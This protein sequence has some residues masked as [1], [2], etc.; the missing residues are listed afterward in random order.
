MS[1]KDCPKH[2]GQRNSA[3]RSELDYLMRELPENQSGTGRHKC[4][5]CAYQKG[6]Q[7]A[8]TDVRA[9]L[10]RLDK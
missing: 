4:P 1:A 6:Y 3:G 10:M 7:Q 9:Q 2:A 8:L 5:Y